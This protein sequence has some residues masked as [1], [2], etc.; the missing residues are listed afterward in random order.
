MSEL[1]NFLSFENVNFFL[2]PKKQIERKIIIELLQ[3][4]R[5]Q[6]NLKNYKYI[7]F[8]SI[9]YYDFI[10]FH[11][12]LNLNNLLSIDDKSTIKRFEFNRPYDFIN[13]ENKFSTDF[14][15]S[16]DWKGNTLFWLDYDKNLNL[17]MLND[18][19][20]IAKNCNRKDILIC[21]VRCS[22]NNFYKKREFERK[23]FEKK[24]NKFISAGIDI[25]KYYTP[26]YLSKL[27]QNVI[28]NYT[29]SMCEHRDIKFKKLFCFTYRDTTPMISFALIFDTNENL[30]KF[31]CDN[32]FFCE[33]KEIKDINVPILTYKE[34]AFL[35]SEIMKICDI[36]KGI[37]EKVE[38]MSIH[39]KDD[40]EKIKT[41]LLSA[42]LPFE[43]QSFN[44]IK[45]YVEYYYKYYPQ[46]YEGVI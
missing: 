9:Y 26:K 14:L 12:L 5:D 45:K 43:I 13:F 6:I 15:S 20:L 7:G 28:L 16:Y 35:D 2:R 17:D 39:Y 30:K 41:E 19:K 18:V 3:D 42:Q 44:L 24:F 10:L 46:Y 29:K 21:T 37:E 32:K 33:E 1:E 4:L 25:R 8:G 27:I 38:K 11:K 22:C 31:K 36:I 34:K 40:V 23:E